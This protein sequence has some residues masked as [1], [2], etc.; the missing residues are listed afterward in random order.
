M[1]KTIYSKFLM[2]FIALLGLGFCCIS[3]IICAVVSSYSIDTK[4]EV[5]QPL[6]HAWDEGKITADSSCSKGGTKTYTC[7]VCFEKKYE[8]IEIPYLK[9]EVEQILSNNKSDA[10]VV[11]NYENITRYNLK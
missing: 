9:L 11:Y 4:T 6:G 1:F 7:T 3:I 5:I 8:T 2:S 10:T